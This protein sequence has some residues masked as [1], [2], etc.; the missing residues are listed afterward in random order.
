VN[1]DPCDIGGSDLDL[2]GIKPRP[3]GD[4]LGDR[5]GNNSAA[6]RTARAE[7]SKVARIPSPVDLTIRPR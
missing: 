7:P 4:A 5:C 3:Q 6:Q 2:A 1:R